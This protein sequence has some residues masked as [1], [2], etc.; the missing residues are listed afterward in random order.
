MAYFAVPRFVRI[1]TE[2]PLTENGKIR[3]VALREA[4][5][6]SDTWDRDAAGYRLRR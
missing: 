2:M 1:V 4:G 3:K 5:K 6:T